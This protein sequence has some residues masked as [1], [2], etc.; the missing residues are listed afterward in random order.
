MPVAFTGGYDDSVARLE[1]V[2]VATG[3][4]HAHSSLDNKE[5]LRTG[6]RV[7]VCSSTV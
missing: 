7:P 2:A 6:V 3:R 1:I 4:P 5:P